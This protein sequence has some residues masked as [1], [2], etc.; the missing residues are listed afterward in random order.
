MR[1]GEYFAAVAGFAMMRNIVTDTPL[2][3][4][5][6]ADVR[7]I[8]EKFDE[9]PQ[10]L[11]IPVQEHDV[12][13][14]YTRWAPNYDGPNPAIER[15]EPIVVPMLS[16]LP[17]GVALDAACGTGRHASTLASLGHAVIGVDATEAMLAVARR[18]VPSADFRQGKL[19]RLPVDDGTIDVVTCS[20][21]LT[22]V[23]R[24]DPVVREFARV[25]R[26]GGVAILSD[27]H[28]VMAMTS[29]VAAF[30]MEDGSLG[31]PYVLNRVH[32]VGEYVEAFVANGL[33]IMNCIEPLVTE[34]ML[35]RFPTHAA[36]PA[37]T[38]DAFIGLPY[39][40]IWKLRKT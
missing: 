26:P 1:A 23:D 11:E 16:A 36:Y 25:L 35:A 33:E 7:R 37:A 13:S 32:Q 22:H 15:E 8:V 39:L 3:Q 6:M 24:L 31:V 20:L 10:S 14:G 40:L 30:P 29:G 34:E 5:R 4:E 38:R 9:F 19:E 18:K 2:A 21:A 12:D 27:M 28:P 17:N